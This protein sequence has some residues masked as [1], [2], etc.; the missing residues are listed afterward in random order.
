MQ[1]LSFFRYLLGRV[2]MVRWTNEEIEFLKANYLD[3]GCKEVSIILQRS[4][5]SVAHKANRL[6]LIDDVE[7]ANIRRTKDKTK[8]EC[9]R[10]HQIFPD[11][12]T[13]FYWERI[14]PATDLEPYCRKCYRE[15]YEEKTLD[16]RTKKA[17]YIKEKKNKRQLSPKQNQKINYD[18]WRKTL[19]G[20]YST[21][22]K[23]SRHRGYSFNLTIEEFETFWKKPCFYCGNEIETIGID[24]VDNN[25]GYQLDNCVSCCTICNRMKMDHSL[26][27]WINHIKKIITHIQSVGENN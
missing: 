7:K 6:G 1:L 25:K 16:R 26:M 14:K 27:D 10:C 9:L 4:K 18:L 23:D 5:I 3:L 19:K 20:C 22:R 12:A 8:K 15:L 13:Y 17:E 11:T 2:V 24:R 21:Y